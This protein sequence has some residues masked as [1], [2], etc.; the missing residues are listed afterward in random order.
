MATAT[1]KDAGQS[2]QQVQKY[3][4]KLTPSARRQLKKMRDIIRAAAPT[5]TEVISYGIPAFRLDGRVL[6]W[7]AAW[8]RHTSLYPI[9]TSDRKVAIAAGYKTAKGTIQFPMDKSVP[10]GLVKKLVKSR[11]AEVRKRRKS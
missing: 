3:F 11:V 5:A 10:A 4:A 2:R 7:Y 6:V 1:R 8:K 9:S